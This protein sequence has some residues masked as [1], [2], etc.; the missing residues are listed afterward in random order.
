MVSVDD[1]AAIARICIH[2]LPGI[3]LHVWEQQRI[4][5]RDDPADVPDDAEKSMR[6]HLWMAQ[7]QAA[8]NALQL[9]LRQ[10]NK[11]VSR[12]ASTESYGLYRDRALVYWFLGNLMNQCPGPAPLVDGQWRMKIPGLLRRLAILVDSGQLNSTDGAVTSVVREVLA[13]QLGDVNKGVDSNA[14][15]ESM[16]TITMRYIMRKDEK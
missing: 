7:G 13:S 2:M 3:L 1:P 5:M 11:T 6:E 8:D 16:D 12:P 4:H 9:W 15:T 14:G 10:W